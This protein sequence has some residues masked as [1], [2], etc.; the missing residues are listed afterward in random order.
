MD[1]FE[2]ELLRP[3]IAT[4][5]P[6]AA[7]AEDREIFEVKELSPGRMGC[8]R[9]LG[10]AISGLEDCHEARQGA[11]AGAGERRL[12]EGKRRAERT[13][14]APLSKDGRGGGG[15]VLCAGLVG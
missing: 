9:C 15:R 14:V 8:P 12:E 2:D 10:L 5:A 1:A 7:V 13:A 3:P 4:A 11:A 6:A